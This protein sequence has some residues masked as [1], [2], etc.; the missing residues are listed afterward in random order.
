MTTSKCAVLLGI[1]LVGAAPLLAE[2]KDGGWSYD[3]NLGFESPNQRFQLDI[4]NRLQARLTADDP[5]IGHS[6][7]SFDLNRYRLIFA[8]RA[9]RHWEFLL[10]TDLARVAQVAHARDHFLFVICCADADIGIVD[11]RQHRVARQRVRPLARELQPDLR[12]A[13]V[14]RDELALGGIGLENQLDRIVGVQGID[15]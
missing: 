14:A 12:V 7:Q 6:G 11:Q 9:F 4:V 2:D 1:L 10:Q 15:R 3:G 13:R 5:D 8:G